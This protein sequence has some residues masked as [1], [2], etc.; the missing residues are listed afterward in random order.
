MRSS[1]RAAAGAVLAIVLGLSAAAGAAPLYTLLDLGTLNPA[2][3]EN[4][5]HAYDVN[6]LGQVVG[7]SNNSEGRSEA[8]RTA[9]NAPI[10]PLTDGLGTLGGLRRGSEAF[11]INDRGQV[12]GW[13]TEPNPPNDTPHAYF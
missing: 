7:S 1:G 11:A 2:E 10:N 12:V 3:P 8:F 6:E 9:P 4:Y 13:V 5:S